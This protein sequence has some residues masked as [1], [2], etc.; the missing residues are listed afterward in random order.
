[1]R[2]IH[3]G[4]WVG[5]SRPDRAGQSVLAKYV[6]GVLFRQAYPPPR[7]VIGEPR[8]RVVVYGIQRKNKELNLEL[9]EFFDEGLPGDPAQANVKTHRRAFHEAL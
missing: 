2:S 5:L 6:G 3:D 4:Q 7:L 8:Q 1:M 9:N